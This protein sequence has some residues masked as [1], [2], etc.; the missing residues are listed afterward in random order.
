MFISRWPYLNRS[1]GELVKPDLR[2]FVYTTW[3][4]DG[5]SGTSIEPV[6]LKPCEFD[7][8]ITTGLTLIGGL[9]GCAGISTSF[10]VKGAACAMSVTDA[11]GTN[12]VAAKR[13]TRIREI[14]VT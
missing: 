4:V 5:A 10:S 7:F 6:T 8:A 1:P 11:D 13:P 2:S 9:P 3:P 14:A 12:T